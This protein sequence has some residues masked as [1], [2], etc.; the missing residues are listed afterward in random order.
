MT[1]GGQASARGR[2]DEGRRGPVARPEGRSVN[3]DTDWQEVPECQLAGVMKEIITR[4]LGLRA[5]YGTQKRILLQKMDVKSEFRQ[6]GVAPD[7]AAAFAYRLEDLVF[8]DILA[9]RMAREPRVVGCGGE[10]DPGSPPGDDVGVGRDIDG[11][12]RGDQTC[13][14]GGA[15]G[16]GCGAV[17]T[18]MP[19][20]CD[21]E[22]REI[23]RGWYF[24]WTTQYR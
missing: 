24:S 22:A 18:G 12:H 2:K 21:A 16:E 13:G 9:V 17:A 20:A 4:I 19:G 5:K 23:Q 10:R 11:S 14:R 6:V 3:A 15:D 8:V 1:F 7:R